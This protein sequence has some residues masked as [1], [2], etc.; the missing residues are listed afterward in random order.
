M[1]FFDGTVVQTATPAM[2]RDFGVKAADLNVTI[3]A[4][5]LAVAVC[6]PASGWLAARF[7]VRRVYLAAIVGFTATS[8]LCAVAPS[9]LVM[10]LVRAAQGVCGAMMVP[11]GRLAVLRGVDKAD[12]LEVVAY[13][14]WPA[15][16]APVVAPAVGGIIADTAGWRWIFLINLPLGIAAVLAA[17]R[18]VP[19]TERSRPVPLD[20]LGLLLLAGALAGVV[21]AG[22]SIDATSTDWTAVAVALAATAV[23]GLLAVTRLRSARHPVLDVRP[24]A[25]HTFRVGN[26]GG[27]VYRLIISA[28]P[29][30]LTLLLQAGFGW[31]ATRA[32]LT[33]AAL[34]IG[35]LAIK[36]V[37]TPVIRRFGFRAVIV[38][39][40]VVGASILAVFVLVTP[41]TPTPVSSP[42]WWRAAPSGPS[43]SAPTTPSSSSTSRR[44]RSTGPTPCPRRCSRW[45]PAWASRSVRC[46][47]SRGWR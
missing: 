12:L 33:V 7:G 29:Y 8:V 24:L 32:G 46:W 22:Q 23:L 27:G 20:W 9:L 4:Y 26:V 41:H 35:N 40:N 14:T 42:S 28:A 45:R 37:T 43:A 1:E 16:L 18:L 36:P 11:V 2:A 15:L 34:F 31:S 21:V 3:T 44:S 39:A 10:S 17:L 6:I 38:W 13:L 19:A 5:L 30:L 25:V 47:S